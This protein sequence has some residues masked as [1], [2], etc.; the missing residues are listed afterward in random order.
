M[1]TKTLSNLNTKVWYRAIKVLYGCFVFI[2]YVIAILSIFSFIFENDTFIV[3]YL[4]TIILKI[5][6]VPWSIFW[7]WFFSKIPQWGFYY[8]YFGS[9][10]SPQ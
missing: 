7:A 4:I 3:S 5:L 8:I 6:Y 2:C 10:R 9:I 1:E